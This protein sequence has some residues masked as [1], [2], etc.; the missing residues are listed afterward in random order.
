[1]L[2]VTGTSG[3]T[4]VVWFGRQLAQIAGRRAASVG[5]LGVMRKDGDV[6]TEYTGF[7][8]PTALKLGPILQTLA[9]EKTEMALLEVSSHALVLGRVDAVRFRAAGLTNIT[10][11]HLDFHGSLAGYLPPSCVCS[12]RCCRR[13]VLR[14]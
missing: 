14:Y 7:T 3:K 2:G 6:E 5:T 1:M 12:V 13:V 4:S 9:G 10:Q 8:S 11:D